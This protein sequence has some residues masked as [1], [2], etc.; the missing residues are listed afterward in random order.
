[1]YTF[2]NGSDGSAPYS[3]LIAAGH[4]LYGTTSAGGS[5]GWGTVFSVNTDGTGFATLHSFTAIPGPYSGEYGG[6]NSD[7]A[8]PYA[9]VILSGSTLYGTTYLG[10]T[11]GYGTVFAVNTDATGFT[12]LYSFTALPPFA[13]GSAPPPSNSDGANPYAGLILSGNTLYGTAYDGGASG[14]GTV[15]SIALP[16]QVQ[17]RIIFSGGLINLTWPTNAAMFSSPPTA[18]AGFTLQV[19]TN[20][21]DPVWTPVQTLTV[22]NGA[23]QFSEPLQ[24]NGAGRFY[25]ISSP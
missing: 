5:S 19:C 16:A 6:T 4:I 23:F 25:R 24:T 14:Y 11:S 21:G 17:P 1:L 13:G 22:T 12:N 20:L 3:Q 9:G 18:G 2:T 8:S 15:F 7:G 10:G